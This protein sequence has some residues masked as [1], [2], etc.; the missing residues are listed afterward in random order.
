[1]ATTTS[2]PSLVPTLELLDFV[3]PSSSGSKID[4][5]PGR[6]HMIYWLEQDIHE[7]ANNWTCQEEFNNGKDFEWPADVTAAQKALIQKKWKVMKDSKSNSNSGSYVAWEA[8]TKLAEE[9]ASDVTTIAIASAPA[10]QKKK[11]GGGGAAPTGAESAKLWL[12]GDDDASA[13][14][15]LLEGATNNILRTGWPYVALDNE[16]ITASIFESQAAGSTSAG[17]VMIVDKKGKFTSY[18][19]GTSNDTIQAAITAA[20]T[21]G[22][23]K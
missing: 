1:M 19:A 9:N 3:R 22:S 6:V 7:L 12:G 8:S 10:P 4:F 13:N 23:K 2:T 15:L 20:K 21:S 17:S 18:P 5:Q 14:V 11:K 16:G